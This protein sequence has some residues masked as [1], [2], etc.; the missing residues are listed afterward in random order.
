MPTALCNKQYVR[1]QSH[2]MIAPIT[3][4]DAI[5]APDSMFVQLLLQNKGGFRSMLRH[6]Y[7]VA[8]QGSS[9]K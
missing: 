4:N 5:Q 2:V 6:N 9:Y 3:S 1:L 8:H 7:I